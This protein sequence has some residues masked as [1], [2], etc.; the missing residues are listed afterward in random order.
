MATELAAALRDTRTSRE[1][2][3]DAHGRI[4]SHEEV[5]ALR[6]GM[7]LSRMDRLERIMVTAAGTLIV[8]MAG[9]I[10]TLLL[11]GHP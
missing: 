3:P 8:G 10:V 7:V 9:L 6:W 2:T 5:C 1:K 11:R 4:D